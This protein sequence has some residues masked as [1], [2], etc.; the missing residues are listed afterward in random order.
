[1]FIYDIHGA[2]TQKKM[3]NV[4]ISLK[5]AF[6]CGRDVWK[7]V[8]ENCR[9][10]PSR[11]RWRRNGEVAS[12]QVHGAAALEWVRAAA[13]ARLQEGADSGR[14]RST[15]IL[16]F[17]LLLLLQLLLLHDRTLSNKKQIRF[18]ARRTGRNPCKFVD[19]YSR[20][21]LLDWAED[22]ISVLGKET[23]EMERAGCQSEARDEESCS[24][25]IKKRNK[26]SP[27]SDPRK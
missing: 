24:A 27:W 4:D 5:L 9:W 16:S 25:P 3:K 13:A 19:F 12:G 8:L 17:R 14:E 2:L 11:C 23:T 20:C 18:V 1:M 21:R 10:L 22:L 6:W 7:D 26:T 15:R